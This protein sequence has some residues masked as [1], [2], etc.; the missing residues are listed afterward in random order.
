MNTKIKCYNDFLGNLL[1]AGFSMSGGN[2]EGIYSVI[3]WNWNE[4]PPYETP[5]RW[6]TGEA[7]TDPWEWRIRVL[8]ERNDI[9][10]GKIF[11]KKGGF[12]TRKW[13]PYFLAARRRSETFEDKYERG[14]MSSYAKRIYDTINEH[15]AAPLH[16]IKAISG[17][18]KEDKS[19]FDRAIVELQ[20]NMFITICGRQQKVSNTG[21]EYG[22]HSTSFSMVDDFWGEEVMNES[23]EID[24]ESAVEKI[25][26]QILRLNPDANEKKIIKF[27]KG[28]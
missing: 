5:V 27:I 7:E 18:G 3:G 9:A 12:I 21:Q 13:Y 2:N 1:E 10:Y 14:V 17:F 25:R 6:H 19:A 11:F 24:E 16:S 23:A 26:N 8:E 28:S 4:Q 15:G 22:W 20:M